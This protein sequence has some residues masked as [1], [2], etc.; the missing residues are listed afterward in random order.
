MDKKYDPLISLILLFVL[1]PLLAAAL[2]P[3]AY[4]AIQHYSPSVM[5]WVHQSEAAGTNLFWADIADSIFTSPFRRVNARIV[6]IVTL[7]LLRPAYRL[8]G[9]KGRKELGI[10]KRPDMWALLGI[11]LSLAVV[12]MLITY[13]LGAA[14]GVYAWTPEAHSAGKIMAELL[15]MVLGAFLI[16]ILEEIFFRGYVLQ[17]LRKSLGLLPAIVIGSAFF[18][19]I[20]FM[21]PSN[22]EVTDQW[23]S[24]FLLF[25][26]LF[27]TGGNSIL[28]QVATL[29]CMGTVLCALTTWTRSV[30]L[31]IGLHT[32]W[33]TV[34]MLFRFFTENQQNMIGLY[35]TGEWISTGWVGPIMALIILLAAWITR[36]RWKAIGDR[37]NTDEQII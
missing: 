1:A 17:A 36:A 24:G 3:W 31:A 14:L 26:N 10:P 8:S 21:K 13:G 20:H 4:S 5:E 6:L 35:G 33:V 30:Y 32:G 28:Q 15:K 12:S 22:P 29:F 34:M 9:L 25:K 37:F 23:Y 2:T 7:L 11:G 18:A 16:G 19:S 27:G